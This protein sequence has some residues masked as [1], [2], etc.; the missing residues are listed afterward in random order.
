MQPKRPIIIGN[1]AGAMEDSPNA[2]SVLGPAAHSGFMWL[3]W[4][5]FVLLGSR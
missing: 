5:I 1:V 4:Q 3:T 2:M